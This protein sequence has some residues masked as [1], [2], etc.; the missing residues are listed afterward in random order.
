MNAKCVEYLEFLN[1]WRSGQNFNRFY[2]D[3]AFLNPLHE[4]T[5]CSLVFIVSS[6][7]SILK[8]DTAGT[9]PSIRR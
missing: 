1:N 5:L 8:E 7:S 9:D 4:D 3:Q 6:Y 2:P